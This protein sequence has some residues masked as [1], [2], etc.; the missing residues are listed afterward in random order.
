MAGNIKQAF[1]ELRETRQE[2][3]DDME[4][5]WSPNPKGNKTDDEAV[6]KLNQTAMAIV[7][8]LMLRMFK[9]FDKHEERTAKHIEHVQTIVNCL[10]IDCCHPAIHRRD[11]AWKKNLLRDGLGSL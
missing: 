2:V 11:C 8:L 1:K 5:S 10:Q 3:D 4:L 7:Y 9:M 6:S